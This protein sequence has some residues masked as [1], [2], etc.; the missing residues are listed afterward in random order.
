MAFNEFEDDYLRYNLYLPCIYVFWPVI[1][2]FLT[3]AKWLKS[4]KSS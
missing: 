3:L 1:Y 4:K 2:P